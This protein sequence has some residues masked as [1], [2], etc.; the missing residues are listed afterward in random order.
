MERQNGTGYKFVCFL[1]ALTLIAAMASCKSSGEESGHAATASFSGEEFRTDEEQTQEESAVQTQET[2]SAETDTLQ[3][4]ASVETDT[5]QESTS[6]QESD[7]SQMD[8]SMEAGIRESLGVP[9]DYVLTEEELAGI[10]DL[11]IWE[12]KI[13]SLKGMEALKSLEILAIGQ[14]ELT[15]ISPLTKLP[16]L[17]QISIYSGYI[18]Q[19][20]EFG[21]ASLVEE[22]HITG[23]K[24]KDPSPAASIPRLKHLDLSSN[25]IQSIAGLKKLKRM[26]TV[27]LQ[28]NDIV[29]YGS[30]KNNPKLQKALVPDYREC[31][32]IENRAKEI[33][34]SMITEDMSDLEK[35]MAIYRYIINTME[36]DERERLEKPP[37]YYGIC[38]HYGVCKDYADAITILGRLA[39]LDILTVSS[40]THSWN[41]INLDGK[42]YHLDAL[43]D[44]PGDTGSFTYFNKS[45]RYMSE[46]GQH[47]YDLKRFPY[48]E[49]DMS[50]SEYVHLLQ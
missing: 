23:N 20:P 8:A 21:A 38:E 32:E 27:N 12:T 15:D 17:K 45:T 46:A 36:Y 39:G 16:N 48:A 19:L 37:G 43:W 42:Y 10:R 18:E 14:S 9:A 3:E 1:T 7:G 44:E 11:Y 30:A 34:A 28:G 33:I 5:S 2:S 40:D 6:V 29:D 47:T 49:E 24:I 13:T 41:M 4:T 35:E 22:I 50:E 25:M 26:E 31:L